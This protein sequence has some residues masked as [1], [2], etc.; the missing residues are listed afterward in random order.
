MIDNLK[1]KN[2]KNQFKH[3]LAYKREQ[4]MIVEKQTT[5]L[6][7]NSQYLF[8]VGG[9]SH[10]VQNLTDKF[11]SNRTM[12]YRHFIQQPLIFLFEKENTSAMV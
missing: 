11:W 4:T 10:S 8:C 9:G 1:L 7:T 6:K 5:T 12:R 3:L 2:R